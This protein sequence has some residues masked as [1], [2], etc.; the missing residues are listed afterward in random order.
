[1]GLNANSSSAIA[2]FARLLT[3]PFRTVRST[4]LFN[5]VLYAAIRCALNRITIAQCRYLNPSTTECYL[6]HCKRAHITPESIEVQGE[7]GKIAAHWI[8]SPDAETVVLYLH[9]GGYTQSASPGNFEYA[10]R[11][12]RDLNGAKGRR[13]IA[14]LFLAYTLAPEA[15]HPT[16]LKEAATVLSH[17]ITKTGRSPSDI[18]ISGDSAGGNL[19]VAVLSHI[20]HP[21]PDVT[22][23]KLQQP[24]LGAM[25]YSPWVGFNTDYPSF[26]NETLDMM[27]PFALRK[28][29][30]MFLGKANPVDPETDPAGPVFGDAWTEACM[31][32]PSW[33]HG[34][35]DVVG[36]IFVS[37][38]SVEVLADP[39]R[40]WKKQLMTGWVEGGGNA[41]RVTFLEGLKEAHVAPILGSMAPGASKKSDTQIAIE[42]WYKIRLQH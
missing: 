2:A 31:N 29:S 14:V 39:I 16:Q 40:V 27:A 5:D 17:L 15:T 41:N 23:I 28:W 6:S 42:E 13:S 36:D 4:A 35:Q 32:D 12:A 19:A 20:L 21:H 34:L 25:L 11:L 7:N 30:A 33:W 10:S 24:L 38:G 22:P 26:D 18:L 3:F 37:Y 9:G 8:G 1:L